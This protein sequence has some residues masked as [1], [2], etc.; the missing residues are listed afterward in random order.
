MEGIDAEKFIQSLEKEYANLK[1]VMD[2]EPVID[3]AIL[4]LCMAT[5]VKCMD[6]S[7]PKKTLDACK[8]TVKSVTEYAITVIDSWAPEGR[9]V[10]YDEEVTEQEWNDLFMES[11]S[12]AEDL[13]QAH[14]D[15]FGSTEEGIMHAYNETLFCLTYMISTGCARCTDQNG[16][17]EHAVKNLDK[18]FEFIEKNCKRIEMKE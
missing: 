16:A 5:A 18:A 6:W 2:K 11:Q 10:F 13:L 8:E 1:L 7:E 3:R 15:A 9:F 4:L 12:L 14:L 17:V